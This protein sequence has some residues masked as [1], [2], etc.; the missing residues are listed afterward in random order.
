[1]SAGLSGCHSH[2]DDQ[3]TYD[4][5]S[6]LA[7][8]RWA[9]LRAKEVN[10]RNGPSTDNAV[11]W[12]Y[13]QPGMPVQIISETHDWRLICDPQGGVAWVS[14]TLLQNRKSVL[15]PASQTVQ[16]RAEPNANA[17]V[18]ANV[19][20]HALVALDKCN[21]DWCRVSIEGVTGWMP[22]ALLWGTQDAP[23]CQRPGLLTG[24]S[25]SAGG[26]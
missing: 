12:T 14:K 7:V 20:P 13:K 3:Q 21:K 11:M 22:Q 10:A 23:A 9:S 18:K 5:P 25:A 2:A 1:M 17:P 24:L 19:R 8:P 4:T 15:T 6:G 16:M 26:H